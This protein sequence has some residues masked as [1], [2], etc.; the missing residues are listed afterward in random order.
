MI[1]RSTPFICF[2]TYNEGRGKIHRG[3]GLA[4]VDRP[5]LLVRVEVRAAATKD[6]ALAGLREVADYLAEDWDDT[7]AEF[8]KNPEG[9]ES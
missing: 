7:V 1:D 5:G 9:E 3:G 8:A 2:D 6:E 4:G